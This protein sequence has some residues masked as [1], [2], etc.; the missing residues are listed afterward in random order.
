MHFSENKTNNSKIC[1]EPQNTLNSQN[2]L[3][4]EEQRW[5]YVPLFQIYLITK[6]LQLKEYGIGIKMDM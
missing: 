4:K 1:M 6:L 2:N 5:R 3:V